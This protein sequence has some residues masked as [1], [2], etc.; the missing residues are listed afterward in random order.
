MPWCYLTVFSHYL[1]ANSTA[2]ASGP[3]IKQITDGTSASEKLRVLTLHVSGSALSVNVISSP[4]L[5]FIWNC[6]TS[7]RTLR[8]TICS[9]KSRLY[10][11]AS[12]KLLLS[13]FLDLHY[14]LRSSL[15]LLLSLSANIK[16]L[17]SLSK[18]TQ[19]WVVI[20]GRPLTLTLI[21]RTIYLDK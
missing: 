14:P 5:K 21:Q 12:E 11:S 1:L 20:L 3:G 9:K 15:L 19:L 10:T 13:M 7:L 2:S 18:F 16:E 4:S 17:F 8:T 6:Q